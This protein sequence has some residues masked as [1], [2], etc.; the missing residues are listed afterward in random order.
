MSEFNLISTAL[1]F[2]K[3][4]LGRAPF[5]CNTYLG[6]A[7]SRVNEAAAFPIKY[8]EERLIEICLWG[9]WGAK[10]FWEYC[11]FTTQV[12]ASWTV[13]PVPFNILRNGQNEVI[14]PV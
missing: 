2:H 7:S 11:G 14:V 1:I 13:K 12:C 10:Q 4:C 5:L 3:A 6:H 8:K 9:S